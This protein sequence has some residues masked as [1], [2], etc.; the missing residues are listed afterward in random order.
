MTMA[1][2]RKSKVAHTCTKKCRLTR[3][4]ISR[5]IRAVDFSEIVGSGESDMADEVSLAGTWAY[6]SYFNQADHRPLGAGLFTFQTPTPTTL[7]GTLEMAN[8]LMLD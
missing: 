6:R 7:T 4:I 1:R 2:W 8:N 3:L 5:C